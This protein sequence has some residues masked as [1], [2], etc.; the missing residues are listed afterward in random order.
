MLMDK[1]DNKVYNTFINERKDP[2]NGKL[3]K[4]LQEIVKHAE[5]I[6]KLNEKLKPEYG[7]YEQI[8]ENARDIVWTTETIRDS[9]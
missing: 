1:K 5:A 3:E 9:Q 6:K 2:Y 8:K 4:I 7:A